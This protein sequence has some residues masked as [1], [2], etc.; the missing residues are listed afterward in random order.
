MTKALFSWKIMPGVQGVLMQSKT[1]RTSLKSALNGFCACAKCF[2][3][4]FFF[5]SFFKAVCVFQCAICEPV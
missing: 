4:F 2:A 3:V 5:F 1:S